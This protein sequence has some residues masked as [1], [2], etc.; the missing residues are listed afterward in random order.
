MVMF[1]VFVPAIV[2]ENSGIIA[3]FGRSSALTKGRRWSIFGMFALIFV[4]LFGAELILM[5]QVRPEDIMAVARSGWT[6][7]VMSAISVIITAYA[8]V[9]TS[10]GY[11][12]LRAEKEGV[13]I[14]DIVKVFD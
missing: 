2:V 9:M 7:W 8:A 5:S 11:Y 6:I 14:E 13:V 4:V 1:W 3:C 10:V 12:Y